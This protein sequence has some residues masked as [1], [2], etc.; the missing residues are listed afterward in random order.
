[1]IHPN[2]RDNEGLVIYYLRREAAIFQG[3]H[4]QSL[5][6]FW[7]TFSEIREHYLRGVI[8]IDFMKADS[9]NEC[10]LKLNVTAV[11]SKH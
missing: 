4:F 8:L 7:R 1:M 11:K 3:G 10:E 9:S 5:D 2:W 6:W